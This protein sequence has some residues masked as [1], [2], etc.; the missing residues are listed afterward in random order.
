MIR[1]RFSIGKELVRTPLTRKMERVVVEKCI[2]AILIR[3]VERKT[4]FRLGDQHWEREDG[5]CPYFY[6]SVNCK[7]DRFHDFASEIEMLLTLTTGFF[8]AKKNTP[9]SSIHF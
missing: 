1:N 9:C 7:F 2:M 5:D 4:S 3:L 6:Y 8:F